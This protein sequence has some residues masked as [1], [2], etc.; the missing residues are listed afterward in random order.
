MSAAYYVTVV[1]HVLAALFW[2]GGMFFLGVVGAPVLRWPA[3]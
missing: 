1:I 2:L 3:A